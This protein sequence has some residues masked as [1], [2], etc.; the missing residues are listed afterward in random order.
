MKPDV[1]IWWKE[2]ASPYWENGG[3]LCSVIEIKAGLCQ[4]E[5]QVTEYQPRCNRIAELHPTTRSP[6]C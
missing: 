3:G 5:A 1:C 2:R 4:G 6:V